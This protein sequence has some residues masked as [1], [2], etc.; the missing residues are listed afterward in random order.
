MRAPQQARAISCSF[1][2]SDCCAS[3]PCLSGRD[4]HRGKCI[5]YRPS[6]RSRDGAYQRHRQ[7]GPMVLLYPQWLPGNHSPTGPIDK[8]AGLKI[9][10]AARAS[11]GRA[12]P[13]SVCVSPART[14]R[15]RARRCPSSIFCRRPARR[16]PRRDD[17]ATCSSAVESLVLYPAGYFSRRIPV[18]ASV[19]LPEG[20]QFGTA[21]ETAILRRR[22][23][24]SSS[25][26]PFDTLVDIPLYAGRYFKRSISIPGAEAPVHMDLV[27]RPA[28]TPRDQARAFEH[29]PRACA[30]R[31]TSCSART[32]TTTTTS[33]SRCPTSWAATAS[34]TT[35]PARTAR[36]RRTSPIGT[37]RAGARPAGPRVHAFL[38]RQVPPPGRSV[39]AEF[40]RADA[41]QPAVGLRR[42]DAVLGLRAGRAL[43]P[44]DASS[45]R[46]THWPR[47]PR[48]TT[49]RPG[50]QWRTLAGH[51][52]R[53]D[54]RHAPPLPWRSWQRSED[55]Y[56][57]GQ[58]IWLDADTLIRERID[59]AN[60]RW[61][62][63]PA[64]SSASTTA[65]TT[66]TTIPSTTSSRR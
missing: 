42:P 3:G 22:I 6:G 46:S 29:A 54:H 9:T 12:T 15:V 65:S 56:S 11:R 60:A 36:S 58:L 51:H 10:R 13:S 1:R 17:A 24:R 8:L 50:R 53:S 20:W 7:S 63:S 28:R 61:T 59:V 45:S 4:P 62:I 18:E 32:T 66:V 34:S 37:R 25:A 38:E 5:R 48:P 2:G 14:R 23:A 30:R 55:Y 49:H 47:W 27:R 16:R 26:R 39:D 33:C 57:E 52:Q 44:V 43:R 19:T 35:N 21:L 64:R 40:Q 41:R 31:P